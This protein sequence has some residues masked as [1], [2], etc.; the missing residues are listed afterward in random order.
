MGDARLRPSRLSRVF[1]AVVVAIGVTVATVVTVVLAR[2]AGDMKPAYF[3]AAPLIVVVGWFPLVVGR[4]GGGIE[5]GLEACVLIFLANVVSPWQA[6]GVWTIGVVAGQVINDKRRLAKAFNSGLGILAGALALLV[7]HLVGGHGQGT[8]RE[9][10]GT[11]LGA[12]IY[13]A[14]DFLITAVS[15]SLE[16]ETPLLEDVARGGAWVSLFAYLAIASLG[17]LGGLVARALPPWSA[18]LLVVPVA[19][20][21]FASREQTRGAENARRLSVLLETAVALSIAGSSAEVLETIRA[22]AADLL[23]NPR[24]VVRDHP[25][26]R[27]EIGVR[28]RGTENETWIVGP[29][30]NR[31]QSTVDDDR[32]GLQAL[33]A[34]ADDALARL[35]LSEAMTHLAWHDPLTSLANRSLF[36]DRAEHAIAV[37]ARRNGRLAV[38]FCDLDGFKR[39]NDLFGHSAGDDLLVEVAGRISAAVRVEDTVARLGGD[40]FAVLLEDVAAPDEVGAACER[41][42][43]ALRHHIELSGEDVSVTITI[44][45]ALS[46][47]ASSAE[48]LLSR[49]DLAMY[50]AKSLGKDRFE[51][52]RAS[53]G[54]QRLQ[55]IELVETLRRAVE[56]RDLEV[57]YQPVLSFAESRIAGVEALARWHHN[58]QPVPPAI[59]IPTAEESGLVVGIG[60]LV[61]DIV[62]ADAPAL[63]QAAGGP[64]SIAINV[65][66]IQLQLDDIVERVLT[67]RT[68]MNGADLVLEVTERDFVRNDTRTIAA[69]T[70]LA[71]ADVRLAIDDFGVGFSSMS[72]LQRLPVRILKVDGSFVTSIERDPRACA[73]VRSMVVLGE[74]LGLD[75]VVEGIETPGQ[76]IHVLEHAGAAH[77]QGY[78]FGYPM[79]LDQMLERL[80][81][82][83]ADA[84]TVASTLTA[85]HG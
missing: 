83:K 1:D 25:P 81:N 37:Q 52:Y 76:L 68:A 67:A 33:V 69:M 15:L 45:V 82:P 55:R 8:V 49:A 56:R 80:A 30:L 22:G 12:A 47:T 10:L 26:T 18:V 29:A 41:I 31:M 35:R 74:A 66:P 5:V 36:M 23:R 63:V 70:A 16:E 32:H 11:A 50:H 79:P 78:L 24:I 51:I 57:V 14:A 7:I 77:G 4:I 59:F 71:E 73:L 28:V 60:D 84:L 61:L 53:F 6:L 64:L 34:V 58:G 9:L 27:S 72:Y 43:G 3:L 13:F 62:A 21:M 40:E 75:V 17:Y 2:G 85:A 20:I 54:Q 48:T 44:G 42:L 39:V 38:L 46:D 19:T 65:S